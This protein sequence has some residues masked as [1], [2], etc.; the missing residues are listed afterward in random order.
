MRHSIFSRSSTPT[1]LA[2]CRTT[3]GSSVSRLNATSDIFRCSATRNSTTPRDVTVEIDPVEQLVR[4]ARALGRVVLVGPLAHVVQEQRQHE[5]LRRLELAEQPRKPLALGTRR[6][7]QAL[8]VSDREERVLVDRV[9]VIEVAHDAAIDRLEF[10][11]DLAEQ[12]RVVHLR[13]PLVQPGFGLRKC[14]NASR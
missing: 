7:D 4:H 14:R 9:L 3:S 2:N 1:R 8:E 11:N 12:S 5:Q 10:G 13:Q 6:V